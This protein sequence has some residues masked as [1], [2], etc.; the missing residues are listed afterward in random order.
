MK[1]SEFR[2]VDTKKIRKWNKKARSSLAKLPSAM[3]EQVMHN[4]SFILINFY[5]S[6]KKL[7]KFCTFLIIV[8]INF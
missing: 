3:F 4:K 6:K 8:N 2:V 7:L 5:S 1:S